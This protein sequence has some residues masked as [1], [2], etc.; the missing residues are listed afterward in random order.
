[1]TTIAA[2]FDMDLTLLDASSGLL[3]FRY[4]LN[5]RLLSLPETVRVAWWIAA[6]KASVLDFP[7]FMARLMAIV[8]GG[9]EAEVLA[10]TESWFRDVVA[11][12]VAEVGRQKVQEHLAQGHI[13]VIVSG[14]TP[15]V[16]SPLARYLGIGDG[17][18]CTHLEVRDGRF[19]GRVL[20]PACFGPGKVIWVERFAAEHHVDLAQSYFYTD[21]HSDLP[22]LER[23]GHPVAVNPNRRLRRFAEQRGWPV[24]RFYDS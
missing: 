2:F 7:H 1:M 16:V 17:Y 9:R 8:R 3:Y 21:S 13:V 24:V 22:L 6:Y 15:Y 5:R 11:P 20:E 12:H 4:L 18:L 19:T 14:A 10:Q 23:V